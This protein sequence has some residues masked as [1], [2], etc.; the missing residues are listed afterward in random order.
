M[1]AKRS[2]GQRAASGTKEWAVRNANCCRGCSNGCIYCY[3]RS[4]NV[5]FGRMAPED[6][7]NEV[8]LEREASKSRRRVPGVTMFPSTHDITPNNLPACERLLK[9]FLKVGNHMLVVSKPRL[10]CI[11]RL[12]DELAAYKHQMLFRFTLGVMD[13][14]L[15]SFWEPGAPEFTERLASLRYAS[16]AGYATS[17]SAE[18]LLEP[19]NVQTLVDSVQPFVTHSI[20]IGKANHLR[21][22][23]AWKLRPDDPEI[24]RLE[25]WQTDEKL[26]KIYKLLKADPLIRWKD[27][28]KKVVGLRR[29][30]KPGLDV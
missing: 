24:V 26:L 30:Q 5:R 15:R 9:N 10:A 21:R 8:V 20:W 6:W 3:G 19:W 11:Q 14:E 12:C 23:T 2:T 16:E 17:V 27:S 4:V 13:A 1:C 22:R 18:P 29:P 7:E 28:Y 25:R